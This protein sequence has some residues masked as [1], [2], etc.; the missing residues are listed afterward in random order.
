MQFIVFRG[1]K[2]DVNCLV[3]SESVRGG[4]GH[5]CKNAQIAQNFE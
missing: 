3:N 2:W 1:Y 5:I 4:G